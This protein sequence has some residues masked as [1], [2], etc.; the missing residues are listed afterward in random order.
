MGALAGKSKKSFEGFIVGASAGKGKPS[1]DGLLWEH[2]QVRVS[3]HL[4]VY[5]GSISR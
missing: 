4:M 3:N 2:Q 1:F 5:C